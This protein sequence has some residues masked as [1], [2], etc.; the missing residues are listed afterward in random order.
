MIEFRG[1]KRFAA[2]PD[3]RAF[4]L[5]LAF[6]AEAGV[7]ILFGPSGAGKTL[8]LDSIA[9]FVRPDE[10]RILVDDVLLFD[11]GANVSLEPRARRCGY[12]F[13]NYA[14]FPHMTLRENLAFAAM[15]LPRLEK[16]RRVA[17]MLERFRLDEVGG[18]RPHELSGGQKQ[19]GS[20][21]RA[22]LASPR[23]LL[24][25]EPARGLDPVLRGELYA[26]LRQVRGTFKI[27][28][29]LV[30]HDLEECFELGE[31]MFVLDEGRLV[32]SGTPA[33]ILE[34]PASAQV[35]RLLGRANLLPACI[36][37][38]D[39][40]QRRSRLRIRPEG[41]EEFELTGPYFPGRLRGDQVVLLIRPEHLRVTPRNGSGAVTMTLERLSER[42]DTIRLHFKGGLVAEVSRDEYDAWGPAREFGVAFPPEAM[43]VVKA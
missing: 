2:R 9:G 38:L 1:R 19:R 25:D 29:L 12:V 18:R 26:V 4:E 15:K 40:V 23:V 7:S 35:A 42:P 11:S 14:L 31:Q 33:A 22:L 6:R 34:T 13:Q 16:R 37:E 43:R 21:A 20:I 17:E 3:S 39:P 41:A 5:D 32:Q 8:T 28:M 27:P 30:T 36:E 24:L 10:G